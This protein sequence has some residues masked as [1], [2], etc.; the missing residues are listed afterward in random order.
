MTATQSIPISEFRAHLPAFLK[1]VKKGKTISITSHGEELAVLS[2][3]EDKAAKARA[4]LL[5]LGKTAI[6]GDIISPSGEKWKAME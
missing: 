3:P 4:R 6:I 1:A 2:P 5:E